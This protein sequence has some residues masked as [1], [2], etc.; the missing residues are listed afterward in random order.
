V[1]RTPASRVATPALLA[2][3]AWS[4]VLLQLWLS[5][6]LAVAN[7]ETVADGVVSLLGYFTVLTNAFVALMATAGVLSVRKGSNSLLYSTSLVGCV[8]TAILFVGLVYQVLLRDL[9]SPQGAQLVADILLHYAVPVGALIHWLIYRHRRL[10]IWAP[11]V[12]CLYPMG[13]LVYM[14]GRGEL[15]GTYPYPFMDV[16]ALGYGRTLLNGAGLLAVFACLGFIVLGGAHL[17]A[18]ARSQQ[19]SAA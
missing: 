4:A 18:P 17:L 3:I 9:W 15:M 12:W 16:I 7:G 10:P 11:L 1:L 6:K 19:E 13:Y 14:L 2:V 8:T 5:V